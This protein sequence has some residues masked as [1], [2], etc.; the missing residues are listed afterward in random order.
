MVA[1]AV[2]DAPS[3][4]RQKFRDE[5]LWQEYARH[6][7]A[8]IGARMRHGIRFEPAPAPSPDDPWDRSMSCID[9]SL[10]ELEGVVRQV[11][12][13]DRIRSYIVN[14][15]AATRAPAEVGLGDHR[16]HGVLD[17]RQVAA[18]EHPLVEAGSEQQ[19]GVG[20]QVAGVVPGPEAAA[21]LGYE[22]AADYEQPCDPLIPHH[23]HLLS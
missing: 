19:G 5:L 20:G 23:A 1:G 9:A 12:L 4:D 13:D 7:Y 6:V 3:K 2:A 8:R 22:Q 11:Y 16:A 10:T 18:L 14:L 21:L 17:D 15:V